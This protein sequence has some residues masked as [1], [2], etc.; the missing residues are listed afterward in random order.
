ML[1]EGSRFPCSILTASPDYDYGDGDGEDNDCGDDD[2][3]YDD[4]DVE[5]NYC[6]DDD[7]DDDDSDTWRKKRC[8]VIS[9]TSSSLTSY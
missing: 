8:W 7:D 1:Q 2:D 5:D 6:D 9:C 3:D 4:G